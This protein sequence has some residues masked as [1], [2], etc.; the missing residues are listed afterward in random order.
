MKNKIDNDKIRLD[1][2][3]PLFIEGMGQVLT[4]AGEKYTPYSWREVTDAVDRYYAALYRHLLMYR[5]GDIY[6]KE[7]GYPHMWHIA[8][9]AMFLDW[10]NRNPNGDI[11]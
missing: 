8:D 11:K 7:S 1:Y 3:D 2:L 9:N 6:D 5:K 4:Q 10:F